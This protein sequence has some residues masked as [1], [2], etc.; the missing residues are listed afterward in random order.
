[1]HI[2]NWERGQIRNYNSSE[3]PELFYYIVDLYLHFTKKYLSLRNKNNFA[4]NC[5]DG[6]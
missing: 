6:I 3:I 2:T 5:P 4:I 1:M